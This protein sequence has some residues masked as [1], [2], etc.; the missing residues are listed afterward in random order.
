M[1]IIFNIVG[2]LFL[3]FV[4]KRGG[5]TRYIFFNIFLLMG[6][7]CLIKNK[8][9]KIKKNKAM[10]MWGIIYI[11]FL[12][13]CFYQSSN[14]LDRYKD[15]FNIIF[16]NIGFLILVSNLEIKE[17][18]Y[19]YILP[20]I[21]LF[22]MGRIVRGLEELPKAIKI[23]G[24]RIGAG[25]YTTIFSIEIGLYIIIGIFGILY[26]KNK[27]EKYLYGTYLSLNL[28]LFYGTKSRT[29]MLMLPLTLL[30]L[31][32]IKNIKKGLIGISIFV[33]ICILGYFNMEK[34]PP[35][36]RFESFKN[37][38]ALKKDTRFAVYKTVIKIEKEN[39]PK[40][41]G[42][43]YFKEHTL[44]TGLERLPHVHNNLLEILM[45]QGIFCLISYVIFQLI[46][47]KKLAEQYLYDD[48]NQ[49]VVGITLSF[50]IFL[51]LTG[52]IDVTLYMTKISQ[53]LYILLT[54]VF[55]SKIKD[56]E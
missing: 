35:L 44:D 39:F 32:F 41:L 52:I 3:F 40:A 37:I 10:Y 7:V 38:S 12:S 1:N 8:F 2:I 53:L 11:V 30:I 25:D 47:L 51:G 9:E 31:L 27:L 36:R 42:F 28:L 15:L 13:I 21:T 50:F 26:G 33:G 46:I 34:I 45:T 22:S 14:K 17:K 48:K 16:Y 43:Y 19:N 56:K 24:Y 20:L 54:L 29:L 18:V 55:V 23:P 4:S 5:D 6:L 49:M